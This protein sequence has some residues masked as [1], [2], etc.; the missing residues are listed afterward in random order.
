[1]E[2]GFKNCFFFFVFWKI[3]VFLF[4]TKFTLKNLRGS[5]EV[6]RMFYLALSQ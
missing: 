5:K 6:V 2:F 3:L 1:M 4:Y